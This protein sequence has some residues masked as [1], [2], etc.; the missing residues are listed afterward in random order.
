MS[1]IVVLEKV[2]NNGSRRP[3]E[4][5]LESNTAEEFDYGNEGIR[6]KAEVKLVG[7]EL[8]ITIPVGSPQFEKDQ[9]WLMPCI[10][11]G[12]RAVN[13]G[14][15]VFPG[16]ETNASGW[17]DEYPVEVVSGAEHLGLDIS[18]VSSAA[19]VWPQLH[20]FKN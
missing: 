15:L 13:N 6:W 7:D 5:N 18:S 11:K 14:K 12:K 3:I 10:F 8:T 17:R 4:W 16:V 1:N 20:I 19:D 9:A 2:F